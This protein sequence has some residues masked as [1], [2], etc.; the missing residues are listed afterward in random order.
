MGEV[1]FMA[2]DM[3]AHAGEASCTGYLSWIE[4]TLSTLQDPN[5]GHDRASLT[6]KLAISALKRE[7]LV[8]HE[9]LIEFENERS[10]NSKMAKMVLSTDSVAIYALNVQHV[11]TAL[12]DCSVRFD[13]AD[14]VTGLLELTDAQ[15]RAFVAIQYGA[16]TDPPFHTPSL[17]S[18]GVVV[19]ELTWPG[20]RTSKAALYVNAAD[21]RNTRESQ[22][23]AALQAIKACD[24]R[25]SSQVASSFEITIYH[26]HYSVTEGG[27]ETPVWV[28][29]TM[30][31]WVT[32][33]D[34]YSIAAREDG[35]HI[36]DHDRLEM[37]ES[38]WPLVLSAIHGLP[39]GGMIGRANNER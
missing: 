30:A 21:D 19:V 6:H 13:R 25:L 17:A 32:G 23:T 28:S 39:A 34:V 22:F 7:Q 9:R 2:P 35:S 12:R 4:R 29:S 31:N 33:P 37:D 3:L 1:Y 18:V 20:A 5:A 14:G 36:A 10:N 24:L 11:Q 27:D 8:V 26:H 16:L 38:E 15:W